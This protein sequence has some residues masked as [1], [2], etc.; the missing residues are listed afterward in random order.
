MRVATALSTK[1]VKAIRKFLKQLSS[2]LMTKFTTS[3]EEEGGVR[4]GWN[5]DLGEDAARAHKEC[6]LALAQLILVPQGFTVPGASEDVFKS[7]QVC[8][9]H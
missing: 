5:S 2:A 7:S 6:A 4:R 1:L 3:F 9:N 8:S